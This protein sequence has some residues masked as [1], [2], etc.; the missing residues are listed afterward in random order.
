[1]GTSEIVLLI[2]ILLLSTTSFIVS[3]FQFRET[4]FLF[5][6]SYIYASKKERI[7]MNKK[8]Y[9]R[10]SAITFGAIGIMFIMIALAIIAN[11][12]WLFPI[13]IVFA[14]LLIVYAIISSAFIERNQK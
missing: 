10:Q 8:P 12:N 3:Y 14:I 1:M 11:W 9:Y 6:N 7:K 4:G 5:N 13:I 2:F